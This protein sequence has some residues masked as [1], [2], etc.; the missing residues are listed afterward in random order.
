M[1]NASSSI[2]GGALRQ[3]NDYL[4][5]LRHGNSFVVVCSNYNFDKILSD[6][7]IKKI[8]LSDSKICLFLNY[9]I[10][11][12]LIEENKPCIFINGSE[13]LPIALWFSRLKMVLLYH[14]TLQ[15]SS[16]FS[17]F[18]SRVIK[19]L[20]KISRRL[21]DVIVF[22][23]ELS[24]RE[25]CFSDLNSYR[26]SVV[27]PHLMTEAKCPIYCG[28]DFIIIADF[29]QHKAI[30]LALEV[31]K[32]I[33]LTLDVKLT[34]VGRIVEIDYYKRIIKL[35]ESLNIK[36][37]VFLKTNSGHDEVLDLLVNHRILLNFSGWESFGYS[38]SEALSRGC[39]PIVDYKSCLP[40]V[41]GPMGVI[42][43]NSSLD[44]P[45]QIAQVSIKS[46]L[47]CLGQ[48]SSYRDNLLSFRKSW[49]KLLE[50]V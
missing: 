17:D 1:F 15:E 35:I 21:S 47:S 41:Y 38:V 24:L 6:N 48:K 5:E 26:K 13:I 46:Y 18:R 36:D 50:K 39:L 33:S 7:N 12:R 34:L 10:W 42:F 28:M 43:V 23:S 19:S 29:Y 11:S 32:I 22:P 14:S 45:S 8:I 9:K 40:E 20:R 44:T 31:F 37:R 4:R 2:S 49:F 25:I 16:L 30:E 3:V 27:I